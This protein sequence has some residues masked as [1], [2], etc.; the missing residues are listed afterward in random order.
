M[1]LFYN[2]CLKDKLIYM[3]IVAIQ[4]KILKI[5]ISVTIKDDQ[6]SKILSSISGD[7]EMIS[8]LD[9]TI[10]ILSVSLKFISCVSIL[11]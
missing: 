7:L 4:E 2:V 9:Y 6:M 11:I 3:L 10:E 8:L 5:H 1:A